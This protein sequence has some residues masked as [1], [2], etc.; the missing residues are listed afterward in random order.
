MRFNSLKIF[1]ILLELSACK[2]SVSNFQWNTQPLNQTKDYYFDYN[3]FQT[4][5]DHEIDTVRVEYY[6]ESL[7]KIVCIT[8]ARMLMRFVL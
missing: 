6:S 5:K 8:T 4:G 7:V 2:S 1:F 3:L